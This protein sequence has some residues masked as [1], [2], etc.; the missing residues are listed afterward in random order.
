MGPEDHIQV[1]F[2]DAEGTLGAIAE[3][4]QRLENGELH[5]LVNNAAI[6]PKADAGQRLSLD[7]HPRSTCGGTCSGREFLRARSCWRAVC[8]T[9]CEGRQG[10]RRLPTSIAGSRVHPFAGT[11]YATSKA[12]LAVLTREMA[13]DFGPLGIRV[14]V[15]A[16]GEI[17]TASVLAGHRKDRRA[18]PAAPAADPRRGRQDHLRAGA[19]TPRPTLMGGDRHQRRTAR[20]SED[21]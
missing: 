6:S 20:V 3:I 7:R 12:A 18:H 8:W 11:A 15:I 21:Q 4:K 1:D 19:P 2:A 14:N 16:P 17:D 9:S 5:A 10:R 13:A